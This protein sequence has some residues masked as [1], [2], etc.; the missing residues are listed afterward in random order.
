MSFYQN[1][2]TETGKP[3]GAVNS[4]TSL[5]PTGL[6]LQIAGINIINPEKLQVTGN[7]PFPW[8]VTLKF[9]GLT[10]IHHEKKTMVIFPDGQNTTLDNSI[11]QTINLEKHG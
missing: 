10:V 3:L 9:C 6:F 1:Y 2:H 11:P 4:L 7:N 5:L 8:P